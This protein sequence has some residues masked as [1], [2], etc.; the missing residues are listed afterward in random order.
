MENSK[1][2]IVK[3]G[4]IKELN[5]AELS[6]FS[7]VTISVQ[8]GAK[9]IFKG[10]LL[11]ACKD[12]K[13]KVI[14]KKEASSDMFFADF[15]DSS[16]TFDFL[17]RLEGEHSEAN[18]N[19]SS[20]SKN[21]EKKKFDISFIHLA[22][23]STSKMN[24]YGVATDTSKLYFKGISHVTNGASKSNASQ[25]AKIIVFDDLVVAQSSPS[26]KIDENDVIAN[27][28]AI[29]GRLNEDH[30]YYLMSRGLNE[31]EARRLIIYGYLSPIANY[32]NL[33]DKEKIINK[34]KEKI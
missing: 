6:G 21:D 7:N 17:V 22:K 32:F 16:F 11:G 23:N 29:V 33:E 3:K 4:T 9:L 27:H 5:F 12:T 20:L 2:L 26:L 1:R 28:A 24:N 13:I 31:E 8:E 19:L 15:S 18:W 25:N 30:L 14:L 34:I 10:L